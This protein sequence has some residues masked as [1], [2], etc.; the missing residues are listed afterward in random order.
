MYCCA[1]AA[2]LQASDT[3][4]HVWGCRCVGAELHFT[5]PP[6]YPSS[7]PARCHVR[8]DAS[9][10]CALADA[11]TAALQEVASQ[12]VRVAACQ[13]R[14]PRVVEQPQCSNAFWRLQVGE[15]VLFSLAE[16]LTSHLE[17]HAQQ[18]QQQEQ[19]QQQVVVEDTPAAPNRGTGAG[20]PAP[21]AAPLRRVLLRL[22]H[23]RQRAPYA[24]TIHGWAAQLGL[25]GGDRRRSGRSGRAEGHPTQP[26]ACSAQCPRGWQPVALSAG[27]APPGE[28]APRCCP[29]PC[30]H[31]PLPGTSPPPML[32]PLQ[33]CCCSAGP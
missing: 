24:R 7:R 2:V 12:Q 6:S 33:A 20:P 26:A 4:T 3:S 31:W 13:Q 30:S 23:M 28:H 19:Q 21:G 5:L 32:L 17:Q 8:G 10:P 29:W 15:E 14:R 11:W 27:L 16:A 25:T 1:I 22:D 18:Q 9:I